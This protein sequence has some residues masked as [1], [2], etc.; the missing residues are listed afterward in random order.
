[1][2]FQKVKKVLSTH[3]HTHRWEYVR[4]GN[5]FPMAKANARTL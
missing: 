4:E 1:M 3:R 2:P 5:Q